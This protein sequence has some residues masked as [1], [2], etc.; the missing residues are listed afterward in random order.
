MYVDIKLK[1]AVSQ[2]LLCLFGVFIPITDLFKI[3]LII[4]FARFHDLM[5]TLANYYFK[6]K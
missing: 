5:L 2:F 3:I 4:L 6:E 1:M